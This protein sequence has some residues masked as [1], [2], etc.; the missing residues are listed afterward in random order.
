MTTVEGLLFLLEIDLAAPW[1]SHVGMGDS[2]MAGYA[3]LETTASYQDAKEAAK[4][5]ERWRFRKIPVLSTEPLL[6]P[7]FIEWAGGLSV[8]G[9]NNE[10]KD[11]SSPSPVSHGA[12]GP[13]TSYGKWLVEQV[14]T[15]PASQRRRKRAPQFVRMSQSREVELESYVPPVEQCWDK[16]GRYKV[17]LKGKWH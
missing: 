13:S 15:H 14:D 17:V 6:G 7:E 5:R 3:L 4:W 2:S 11:V 1:A 16:A 8:L 12:I 9:G 10:D